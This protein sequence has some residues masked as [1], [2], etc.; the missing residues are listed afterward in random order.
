MTAKLLGLI[1]TTMGCGLTVRAYLAACRAQLRTLHALDTLLE[2]MQGELENSAPTLAQL[3]DRVGP[4]L[5]EPACAFAAAVRAGMGELGTRSFSE[6]WT[7]AVSA[8]LPELRAAE[9]ETLG[10]L[11]AVLGRYELNRQLEALSSCRRA[12]ERREEQERAALG[13]RRRL[14]FGLGLSAVGLLW[15]VL[16]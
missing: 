2:R 15:I 4:G 11:G 6:I 1:L 9:A 10:E 3:L 13:E 12:L 7:A 5:S 16:V 8:A 14:A